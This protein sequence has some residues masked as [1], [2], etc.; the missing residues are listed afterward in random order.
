[1]YC[2]CIGDEDI[3]TFKGLL[4]RYSDIIIIKKICGERVKKRMGIGLRIAKTNKDID[5]KDVS[6]LRY[7]VVVNFIKYYGLAT[8]RNSNYLDDVKIWMC[9]MYFHKKSID[10][11]TAHS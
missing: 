5:G 11:K 7:K 8:R 3:K 4:D 1:M 2:K 9:A 10:G 6:K